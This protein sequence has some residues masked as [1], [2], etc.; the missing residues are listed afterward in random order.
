[1]TDSW[2]LLALVLLAGFASTD[3]WRLLGIVLS[4]GLDADGP[5]MLWVR[6]VATALVMAL[7]MRLVLF[8]GGRLATAGLGWRLASVGVAVLAF[9][10]LRRNLPGA[11]LVGLITLMIGET[12]WPGVGSGWL[13]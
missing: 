7:V 6:A 2:T 1:M 8:P 4:R 9:V 3:V 11:V 12:L 13:K 10:L 5:V